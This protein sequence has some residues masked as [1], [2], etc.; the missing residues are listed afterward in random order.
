MSIPFTQYMM[1]DGRRVPV[2]IERPKD[3][4]AIAQRFIDAGG[5]FECEMLSTGEISLTAV[6]EIDGEE[7]DACI[8]LC[9]NGPA[10]P[11]AVDRLVRAAIAKAQ[12]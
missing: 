1:P 6:C 7:Q 10:V 3:V 11:E 12:P 2:S 5:R 9:G 4:E 8:E